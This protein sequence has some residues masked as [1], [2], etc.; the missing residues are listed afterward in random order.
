M[1]QGK[2]MERIPDFDD[3]RVVERPDGVYWQEPLTGREHGPFAT[4]A[5]AISD[6]DLEEAPADAEEPL[7]VAETL[8]EAE[9]EIGIADWIDPESGTPAEESR[10]HLE[11]H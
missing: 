1:T 7:E 3:G 4:L 8:E 5:E 9:A 6:M 10:P 11:E 2:P